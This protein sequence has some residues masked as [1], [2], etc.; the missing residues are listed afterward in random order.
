L[1][2]AEKPNASLPPPHVKTIH[3]ESE[4]EKKVELISAASMTAKTF[5]AN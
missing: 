5:K 1:S 4:R 2:G 3:G